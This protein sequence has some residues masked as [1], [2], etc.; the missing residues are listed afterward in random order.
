MSI[1][2]REL[3]R[4]FELE[5]PRRTAAHL[6]EALREKHLK[7]DEFS[8]RD[9]A[10]ALVPDGREWVRELDPRGGGGALRVLEAEGVDV[11][12]F[13]NVT[14]QVIYT[15]VM[16]AYQQEAFVVSKLVDTIPT[17]LDGEK[18]PGASHV[19][20]KIDVV[21]PGMPYPS[22][23]FGEDYIETPS[24]SKRGFIVSVTKEAVFFDRTNL[25]LRRAA[26]VGEL[27]GLNKE[28]RLVDLVIGATNNYK[29]RGASYNTY[30]AAAPWVNVKTGNELVDWTDVDAAELLLADRRRQPPGGLRRPRAAGVPGRGGRGGRSRP[31]SR[32]GLAEKPSGRAA[33]R[34]RLFSAGRRRF[35]IERLPRRRQHGGVVRRAAAARLHGAARLDAHPIRAA[36][37][38]GVE[39]LRRAQ[40]R[41]RGLRTRRAGR[42]SG[43]GPVPNDR[44][45]VARP[46]AILGSSGGAG[47]R[48]AAGDAPRRRAGTVSLGPPWLGAHSCRETT[49]LRYNTSTSS[50]SRSAWGVSM[51]RATLP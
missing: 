43:P 24:T 6:S 48:V 9:L 41:L 30:Q 47:L 33:N 3:R 1:N 27:L 50:T 45:R 51:T 38:A 36:R 12:A 26:E 19:A 35:A 13:A 15:K 29:W 34:G 18:I 14:G 40:A 23:G 10:E 49:T 37:Q 4:R 25:V 8:L 20:D 39:C 17:R 22:L 7:P 44:R 42:R 2:Y 21:E 5:G 31:G 46:Q 28:K 11:T 32:R 16:E